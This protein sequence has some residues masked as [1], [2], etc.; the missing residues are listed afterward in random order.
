MEVD[1]RTAWVSTTALR[2]A[3]LT[4]ADSRP[5]PVESTR[6]FELQYAD[7]AALPSHTAAGL[8][9]NLDTLTESYQRAGLIVNVIKTK[10]LTQVPAAR[11]STTPAF[12]VAS[13]NLN[14][15]QQFT[16][17]GSI[18]TDDCDLTNEI[19]HRIKLSSAAIGRLS[20]RVFLNHNLTVATKT[21]V[22]HAICLSILINGIESWTLSQTC[23]R[24]THGEQPGTVVCS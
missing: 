16:Y 10:V 6:V 7:D 11:T 5:R 20:Q 17:L 22:Y 24:G 4:F 12:S 19:N 8:Q 14:N 2:A 18:L 21:S 9:R 23:H 3:C 1:Q 15:V 13:S